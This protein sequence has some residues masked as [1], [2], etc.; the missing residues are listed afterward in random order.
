[1]SKV[2]IYMKITTILK[3]IL[4]GTMMVSFVSC[5]QSDPSEEKV[6]ATDV[7]I[8]LDVDKVTLGTANIR[9]RHTAAADM[10]WVYMTTSDLETPASVLLE[11]KLAIEREDMQEIVAYTGTN[12]SILIDNLAPKSYYRFIC[13]AIDAQTGKT[14][15]TPSEIQ[16]RTRRDPSVFEVNDNW[17]VTV[18]DRVVNN[19]DKMEY[20][21]FIIDSNDEE[22][23][24]LVPLKVVDF[25]FYYS[26]DLQLFFEDFVSD[27]GLEVGSSKW[28]DIVKSGDMTW[29]E[30]RLRSG[31]WFIFLIGVDTEGELTG[32][33]LKHELTVKQEE[34]TAE[35][36]RWL[37]KWEVISKDGI[38]MFEI[39]VLPSENNMWYYLSGWESENVYQFDTKDQTLMAELFFDKETGEMCFISQYLNTMIDDAGSYDFYFSGTFTYGNTYVL[40]SEVLNYRM[41]DAVFLNDSYTSARVE[42]NNFVTAQGTFPIEQICIMYSYA[43]NLSAISLAPPA[44][45]LTLKKVE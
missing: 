29:P 43:G 17:S 8:L 32:Y 33:Y 44:L 19:S 7:T 36:N 28:K 9:V 22:S 1:M 18:G 37:G 31:D 12:K 24:L 38:K 16:F 5:Q 25:E 27:F 30:Q 6:A 2:K 13:Q 35:Y 26:N 10:P 14:I 40:G 45:P 4:V 39:D 41:A 15:G 42:A 20:D 3:T 23:Y 11:E 34:A 21:N